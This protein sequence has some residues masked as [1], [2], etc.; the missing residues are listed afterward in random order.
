MNIIGVTFARGGSKGVVDKNIRELCSKP[1]L[2]YAVETGKKVKS[3]NRMIV[4]TDS[5]K[6]AEIALKYGAEVPFV[7]PDELATDDSPE[8]LSW[9][10]A[11][12]VLEKDSCEKID[13][14]V[15]LPAT[16]PLREDMDVE[17]AIEKLLTTDVDIVIGVCRSDRSPYFNMVTLD[18]KGNASVIIDGVDVSRRQDVPEVFDVTTVVYAARAEYVK[19]ASKVLEGKVGT[20]IIPKQRAID[21]DSEYDFNI[22]EYLI[23][24]NSQ[25]K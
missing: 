20:V 11:I 8:I 14:L 19:R 6:I 16:S 15:S 7:R 10:H 3:I 12:D 21:I 22:A 9:K 23:K 24:T 1:L 17:K 13:I 18:D 4:S 2:A 25:S 5:K